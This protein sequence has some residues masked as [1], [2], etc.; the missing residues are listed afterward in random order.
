MTNFIH[1][2]EGPNLNLVHLRESKH[3]GDL[4]SKDIQKYCSEKSKS[5]NYGFKYFQ[6]NSE[7]EIIDY[8]HSLIE[9]GIAGIIVNLGGFSHSSIALHDALKMVPCPKIEVHLS[10]LHRRE[11]FRQSLI[12]AKACHGMI[13]G[14]GSQGYLFAIEALAKSFSEEKG[15]EKCMIP[16]NFGK[17]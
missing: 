11:D 7:S 8:L 17:D 15:K 3:Y 12:T 10:Y 5:L 4:K 16:T 13:S 6:S 1:L 2:I 9:S 14:F